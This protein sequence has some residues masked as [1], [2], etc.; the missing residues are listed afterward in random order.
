MVAARIATLTHGGDRSKSPI[1]DLKQAEAADLLNVGKRSVERARVILEDGTPELI[2]AV[3][4][5]E[6]AVS[7]AARPRSSNRASRR[8]RLRVISSPSSAAGRAGGLLWGFGRIEGLN[9][10]CASRESC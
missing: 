3:E 10:L 1:G 8:G 4:R 5:D 9:H 2:E 6:I 7:Q